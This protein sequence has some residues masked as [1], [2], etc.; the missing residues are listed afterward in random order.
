MN[1]NGFAFWTSSC[2]VTLVLIASFVISG[3]PGEQRLV[4]LDELRIAHLVQL[5]EAVDDYW[6]AQDELPLKMSELLDGRRL[7]RMP[8]DPETGLAYE[9]EQLDPTSYQLCASFD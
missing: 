4:R 8:S 7:S 3:S 6:E 5:T 2:A 1:V 9:Y